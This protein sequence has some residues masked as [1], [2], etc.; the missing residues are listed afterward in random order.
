[1]CR[2]VIAAKLAIAIAKPE[3]TGSGKAWDG[4][5]FFVRKTVRVNCGEFTGK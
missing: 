2:V 3:S 4:E 5:V 1:M